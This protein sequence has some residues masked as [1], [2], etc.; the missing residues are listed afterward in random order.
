MIPPAP[1]DAPLPATH[2]EPSRHRLGGERKRDIAVSAVLAALGFAA[3][4]VSLRMG[5]PLR[6]AIGP[7]YVPTIVAICLAVL[8]LGQ[9]V[10]ALRGPSMFPATDTHPKG[11]PDFRP[12][13][14]WTGAAALLAGSVW[15]WSVAGYM[16]GTVCAVVG[17]MLIDRKVKPRWALPFAML[18]CGSL[19]VLFHV[20]F[21]IELG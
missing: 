6:Q 14:L 5:N 2:A 11:G 15:V 8:A 16:A 12:S 20:L 10:R 21:K 7:G 17:V 1:L 4:G 3:A 18:L 19:W 13:L 9:T